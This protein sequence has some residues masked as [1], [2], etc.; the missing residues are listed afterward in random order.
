MSD[1]ALRSKLRN[2]FGWKLYGFT[3]DLLLSRD[4]QTIASI[5]EAAELEGLLG[6][7]DADQEPEEAA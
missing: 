6:T 5:Q 1:S 2:E 7:D 4:G 3:G